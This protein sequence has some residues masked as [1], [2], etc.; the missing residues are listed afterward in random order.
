MYT[1]VS[2]L[3]SVHPLLTNY[4]HISINSYIRMKDTHL[5]LKNN[6]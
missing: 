5:N 4:S 6:T 3:R 2:H 1:E